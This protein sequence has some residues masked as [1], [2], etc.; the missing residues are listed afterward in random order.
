MLISKMI[1]VVSPARKKGTLANR[2]ILKGYVIE[3]GM[4]EFEGIYDMERGST[5][6][7]FELDLEPM[8][9]GTLT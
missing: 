6:V 5:E 4:F 2:V 8:K 1:Q 3:I 7:V 9:F